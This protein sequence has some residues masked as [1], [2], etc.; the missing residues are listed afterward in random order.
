MVSYRKGVATA[1]GAEA[2]REF[3]EHP[4]NVA[5]WFKVTINLLCRNPHLSVTK[6]DLRIKLHL[7]PTVTDPSKN[8]NPHIPPLPAGVTIERVYA[9]MMRYLMENTKKFF[10]ANTVDGEATWA[11]LR[12]DI[13]IL[14][15]TPNG[16]DI[17]EQSTLRKAAIRASLVTETN[18]SQ[19]LQFVT[20]ASVHYVLA[21]QPS[22]WL[23]KATVFAV[24][25][26]GGSTV[27]TTVYRCVSP[28]PLSIE[29]TCPSECVQVFQQYRVQDRECSRTDIFMRQ[30][31]SSSTAE[32]RNCWKRNS[33]GRHSVIL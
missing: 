8:E 5:Y 6:S 13:V 9:D 3:E 18:A 30:E 32:S 1:C 17:R 22:E 15:A 20:E 23:Q 16:W 10:V 14:L 33:K 29:E 31:A 2:M 11:R 19:L 24:I 26:C 28:S 27:D 7:H 4:E 12:G 21:R 25:D